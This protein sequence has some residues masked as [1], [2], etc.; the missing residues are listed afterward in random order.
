[1]AAVV[2]ALYATAKSEFEKAGIDDPAFNSA[3]L[4]EKAFGLSR[5]EI[6][7]GK[8]V[9]P[10]SEAVGFIRDVGRRLI[11]EPLQYI[12]GEWE[13]YGNKLKVGEGVLIP[14][15][16]TEVLLRDCLG[17]LKNR[18]GARVLDLC[19]GS[20]ALAIAIAKECEAEVVAVE[21]SPE[22]YDYLYNNIAS[23]KAKVVPVRGDIF[24]LADE[25]PDGYFDL[26]LSNPP[27]VRSDDIDGLQR[28]IAFEP[29][30]ALDGG[31]DGLH[32]YRGIIKLWTRKLR[33]GGMLAFELGEG[34][35]EDVRGLMEDAGLSEIG[36]SLDL[37]GI[38]RSIFGIAQSHK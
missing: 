22:A 30:M 10:D 3:A 4:C 32:F 27:Y 8:H 36:G 20:G 1:M 12:L 38:K 31:E 37:G 28:E 14:R 34:Q 25:F 15:D 2:K 24:T 16:D 29:R 18:S 21:K 23:N 13:F 7:A 19:S 9:V 5:A 33:D 17:V 26:I 35:F 6:M 11:G